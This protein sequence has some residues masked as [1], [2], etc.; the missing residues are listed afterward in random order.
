MVGNATIPQ[1]RYQELAERIRNGFVELEAAMPDKWELLEGIYF[2]PILL[3]NVRLPHACDLNMATAISGVVAVG[4]GLFEWAS[5]FFRHFNNFQILC[6]L[7][8]SPVLRMSVFNLIALESW[9]IEQIQWPRQSRRSDG[10]PWCASQQQAQRQLRPPVTV[11]CRGPCPRPSWHGAAQPGDARL[12][13]GRG[14]RPS[15]WRSHSEAGRSVS[16]NTAY[17]S[18]YSHDSFILENS[19]ISNLKWY[20]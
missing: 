5:I 15:R 8:H 6:C 16:A 3:F 2:N 11:P 14:H 1:A 10:P 19:P 13:D 12:P 7:Q 17:R 20:G 4:G 9:H 18:S